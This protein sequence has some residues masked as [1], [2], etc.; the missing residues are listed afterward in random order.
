MIYS[1]VITVLAAEICPAINRLILHFYPDQSI[2]SKG[3]DG[4]G[5][6]TSKAH[7]LQFENGAKQLLYT[8]VDP[9]G[10]RT[11]W[12]WGPE[13]RLRFFEQR[14]LWSFPETILRAW[15]GYYCR[16]YNRKQERPAGYGSPL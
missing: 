3:D 2:K 11:Y 14:L 1:G 9:T 12:Q 6:Q 15:G 8:G 5:V 4:I 7:T 16:L 10:G 13:A